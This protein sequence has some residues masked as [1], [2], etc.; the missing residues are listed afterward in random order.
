M[1]QAQERVWLT[2][3][4]KLV[5]DGHKDAKVL[6]AAEGQ[7]VP[8]EYLK[9]HDNADDFFKKEEP[10][11]REPV[12][13]SPRVEQFKPGQTNSTASGGP[14]EKRSA[15]KVIGDPDAAVSQK[16]Q[17]TLTPKPQPG[18]GTKSDADTKTDT[19]KTRK[20]SARKTTARKTATRKR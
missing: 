13:P 7:V 14:A 12:F 20:T 18:Q 5:K 2:D 6:F 9:G 10:K 19:T 11:P 16:G 4:N 17:D 15:V 3:E 8:D 1:K